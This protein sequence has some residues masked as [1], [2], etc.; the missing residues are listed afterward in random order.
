MLL[1]ILINIYNIYQP[2][3]QTGF[4][5]LLPPQKD[6][7]HSSFNLYFQPLAHDNND[8]LSVPM[9]LPFLECY[10]NGII[11]NVSF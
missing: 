7:S 10:K 2:P 6:P 8:L 9:V 11:K 4:K 5:I 1:C 3:P